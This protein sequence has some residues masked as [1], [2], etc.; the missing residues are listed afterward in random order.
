MGT[1]LKGAM[2]N[3]CGH[4]HRSLAREVKPCRCQGKIP[5]MDCWLMEGTPVSVMAHSNLVLNFHYKGES[6]TQIR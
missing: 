5:V 2:G 4:I 3:H 6:W 1:P